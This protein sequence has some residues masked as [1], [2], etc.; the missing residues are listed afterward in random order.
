MTDVL[1]G[2]YD[3]TSVVHN[4]TYPAIDPAKANLIGKAVFIS[5]ASRGLG[6]AMSASFAKSGASYIAIGAR[7]DLSATIKEMREASGAAGKPEPKVLPVQFDV[8]N[9]HSVEKAVTAVKD[10]FGRIDIV[11]NNAG[12]LTAG[13]IAD[14]DPDEWWRTFQVNLVGPYLLTR[15]F[16]PLM[17][18]AG[19]DKTFVTVSSVGAHLRSPGLSAYQ[20]SKLAV[21]RFTEFVGADYGDRGV[22]AYAIHPGNI[23]TD[24]LGDAGEISPELRAGEYIHYIHTY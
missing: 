14:A 21:L 10:A 3:M 8:T 18:E 24:M 11:I 23:P 19:G 9:R 17:L 22:L 6:R 12:V 16:I 1:I 2:D 20:T 5:G 4:D 7:S 13:K 15:G